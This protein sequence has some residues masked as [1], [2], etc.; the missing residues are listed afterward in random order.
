ML[1][2]KKRPTAIWFENP[3]YTDISFEMLDFGRDSY[4]VALD[5]GQYFYYGNYK[6]F[7]A[8]Y[9]EMGSVVNAVST[10]IVVEYY[11]GSAWVSVS[12][13]VDETKAF[14]RSGFVQFDRP[15]DWASVSVNG[16]DAYFVRLS[17][18][19]TLTA[20]MLIQGINVLFSDD[21]DLVGVYPTV[22]DYLSAAEISFVLRHQNS[23]DLIMQDLRNHGMQKA[24]IG[25]G[26]YENLEPIDILE[27]DEVR[28]WS[29]YLTLSN[30]FSSLQ[31]RE[32]DFYKEKSDEYRTKAEFYKAA[33]Y[34]SIDRNDD[35]L[36]DSVESARDI[37]SKR[38]VRG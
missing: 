10:S 15:S 5:A 35:G 24:A 31:A 16:V 38:L 21:R 20:G 36:L 29:T 14:S 23:R 27:I 19:I 33:A 25:A 26:K 34:L 2:Q 9:V 37:T 8:F 18:P 28:L 17:V 7:K 4:N 22:M 32:G 1:K 6:P 13:C 12:D 30:I 11:D 3:A